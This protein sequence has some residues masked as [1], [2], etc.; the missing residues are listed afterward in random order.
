[1]SLDGSTLDVADTVEDDTAFG[2]PG[3]SLDSS[4][5]PK[6]RFVALPENGTHVLLSLIHI[7]SN[8]LMGALLHPVFHTKC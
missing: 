8:E 4:A 7:W 1:M 5:F 2:R 6:I 3:A